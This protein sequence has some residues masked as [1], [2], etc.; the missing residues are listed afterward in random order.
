MIILASFLRGDKERGITSAFPKVPLEFGEDGD[1]SLKILQEADYIAR[2]SGK[3]DFPWRYFV[4]TADDKVIVE[5]TMNC[6]LS[7]QS[8]LEDVSW[9]HPGQVSWE[10]WNGASPYGDDVNFVSGFNLNTYKYYIDFAA[11]HGIPYILLDEGWA[12]STYDPYTPNPEVDVHELIRYGKEKNVGIVLW[13]TWL[14][15]DRHPELFAKFHE[16]GSERR[17]D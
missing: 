12:A 14:C 5:N 11:K 16:W 1:R 10:W 13:L 4:V 9:I 8:K 7:G 2:T 17:E 6:R 15:V 3:R